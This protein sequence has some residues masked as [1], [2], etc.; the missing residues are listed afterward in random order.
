MDVPSLAEFREES[1]LKTYLVRI[2][3]NLSLNALKRRRRFSLRFVTFTMSAT[4]SI[5]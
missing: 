1:A 3:M 2:A 4:K 5:C